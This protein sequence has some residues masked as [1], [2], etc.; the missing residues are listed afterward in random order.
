MEKLNKERMFAFE[1]LLVWQKSIDF[2]EAVINTIDLFETPRKHYRIIEQLESA[3]ISISSNIAEGKGRFRR[4]NNKNAQF[5][6]QAY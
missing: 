1:D 4:R 5:L 3:A 6:D 2:A